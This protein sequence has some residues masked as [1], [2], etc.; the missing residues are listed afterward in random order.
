MTPGDRWLA[1]TWPFVQRHLPAPPA[2]VIELGCGPLGGFVPMLR[3]T[4]YDAVGDYPPIGTYPAGS[5]GSS[6]FIG[7]SVPRTGTYAVQGEDELKGYELAVDLPFMILAPHSWSEFF[8]Y[9]THRLADWDSL[10]F[11]ACDPFGSGGCGKTRFVEELG[12][13]AQNEGALVVWGRVD[14]IDGSP[15]YW[16]WLQVFEALLATVDPRV[17]ADALAEH[18]WAISAIV[19]A[20]AAFVE[21]VGP[22]AQLAPSAR[23]RRHRIAAPM[24]AQRLW[25]RGQPSLPRRRMRPR[26]RS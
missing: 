24:C 18:A 25:P 19:P 12:A 1:A 21:G 23:S 10:W 3:A 26:K 14:D 11:I 22:T 9:N 5:S 8:R 15:P 6:V 20:A 2:Q 17:L 13:L 7:I 16:P 4:G